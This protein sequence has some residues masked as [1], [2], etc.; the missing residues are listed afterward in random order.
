MQGPQSTAE[1]IEVTK[2]GDTCFEISALKN[3]KIS[4]QDTEFLGN[5]L[6]HLS[7]IRNSDSYIKN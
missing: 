7:V 2:T 6:L 1:L 3:A 4:K 5:F